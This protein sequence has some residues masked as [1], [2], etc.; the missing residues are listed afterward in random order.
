LHLDIQKY[1]F[2]VKEV[3]YLGYIITAGKLVKLDLE[4]VKAI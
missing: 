4:K 1:K 3:L 2:I